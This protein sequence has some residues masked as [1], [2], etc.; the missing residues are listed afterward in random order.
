VKQD[1]ADPVLR[2]TRHIIFFNDPPPDLNWETWTHIS[3]GT[4][5][6]R[7]KGQ[8]KV[9]AAAHTSTTKAFNKIAHYFNVT[10][11]TTKLAEFARP[12]NYTM[13]L[14]SIH[15]NNSRVIGDLDEIQR[16]RAWLERLDDPVNIDSHHRNLAKHHPHTGEWLFEKS[17]FRKWR[18][19]D[20][21]VPIVWLV[22]PQGCGKSILCSLAIER[23]QLHTEQQAVIYL[24][25][26]FDK[27][28]SEYR[29][30]TQVALQLFDY[31]A[32]HQGGVAA[33][34]FLM[35]LSSEQTEDKKTSQ[36]YE[37]I[38][39]LI[40]QCPAVFIFIDGLD[41]ADLGEQGE[42]QSKEKTNFGEPMK[43]LHSLLSVL[44]CVAKDETGTPTRLWCSSRQTVTINKWMREL[45][46]LKLFVYGEAVTDDIALFQKERSAWS[47]DLPN[48]AKDNFLLASMMVDT[49]KSP[50]RVTG[51]FT[52]VAT[53]NSAQ[54]IV[55]L[56][57][58]RLDRISRSTDPSE[59]DAQRQ[60]SI[61]M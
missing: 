60:T 10:F 25:L 27:P 6:E 59:Y 29:L 49:L 17:E 12:A 2:K 46:V 53:Q 54:S 14:K 16:I 19:L 55:E 41:S 37:L 52:E 5:G 30:A 22:G 20:S 33:E 28:R 35:L 42:H 8:W 61:V 31:V 43:H 34:A 3:K 18:L 40:S 44:A 26:A 9:W 48:A 56:Y 15:D 57:Q 4:S 47:S 39:I 45:A 32:E 23:L 21:D 50:R 7:S 24:M 58:E 1:Q 36:V 13:V 11:A 51:N 38:K